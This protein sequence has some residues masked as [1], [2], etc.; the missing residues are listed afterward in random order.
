V[1]YIDVHG[2][3]ERPERWAQA[4]FEPSFEAAT[5]YVDGKIRELYDYFWR[6]RRASCSSS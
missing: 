3:Q 6:A 4:P 1:H 2:P 5:R